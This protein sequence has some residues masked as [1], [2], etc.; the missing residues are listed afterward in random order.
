MKRKIYW[1]RFRSIFWNSFLMFRTNQVPV[2]AS[3]LSFSSMLSFVPLVVILTWVSTSI[4]KI[5]LFGNVLSQLTNTWGIEIPLDLLENLLAHTQKIK[6]AKMGIVGSVTLFATS[7]LAISNLEKSLNIIWNLKKNRNWLKRLY[8]YTPFLIFLGL[9]VI[10]NSWILAKFQIHIQ[11][12][13][14]NSTSL[15]FSHAVPFT[16][17]FS[18]ITGLTWILITIM[19]YIIPYTR[20]KFRS[21]ITGST[22]ITL[23]LFV[24]FYLAIKLQSLFLLRYS[25]LYGSLASLP[26]LMLVLYISWII[27]L[28]G[29]TL[30]YAHQK[31]QL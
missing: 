19:Y 24:F 23:L 1:K 26:I 25:V 2:R 6:M 29:A 3:A 13:L 31:A 5:N 12:A 28:Y 14:H 15:N 27:I 9:F 17:A 30:S 10:I 22:L 20:V 11:E 16:F 7:L 21:A 8:I 18:M 4:V